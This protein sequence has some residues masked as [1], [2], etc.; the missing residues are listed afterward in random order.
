M[1]EGL[2]KNVWGDKIEGDNIYYDTGNEQ[3]IDTVREGV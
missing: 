2:G 1:S 3:I